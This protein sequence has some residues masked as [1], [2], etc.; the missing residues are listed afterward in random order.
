MKRRG[1]HAFFPHARARREVDLRKFGLGAGLFLA[2][3]CLGAP[4]G[5]ADFDHRAGITLMDTLSVDAVE[6]G[7]VALARRYGLAA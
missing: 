2:V 3:L 4:V 5:A 7:A 1:Y 6:A